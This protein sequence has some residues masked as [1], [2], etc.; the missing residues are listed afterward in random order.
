MNE[1][2]IEEYKNFLNNGKTERECVNELVKLAE[3]KGYKDI[4]NFETLKAGDKIYIKKMN[5]A[6]ALFEIGTEKIGETNS[7][8]I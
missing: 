3:E 6:I 4:C 8:S 2:L 7:F 1:Q 5:K